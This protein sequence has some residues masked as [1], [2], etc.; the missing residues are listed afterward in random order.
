MNLGFFPRL[1]GIISSCFLP[2]DVHLEFSPGDLNWT[3]VISTF[4]TWL[5]RCLLLLLHSPSP[6]LSKELQVPSLS[7]SSC[8]SERSRFEPSLGPSP[9]WAEAQAHPQ[10]HHAN[11]SWHCLSPSS[12]ALITINKMLYS[13]NMMSVVLTSV[14]PAS[15]L[16]N[17]WFSFFCF[18]TYLWNIP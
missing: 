16:V 13:S 1:T 14:I 4:W 11:G 5:H 17:D 8:F 18:K 12:R 3:E 10:R 15:A 2:K 7:V 6:V 9:S